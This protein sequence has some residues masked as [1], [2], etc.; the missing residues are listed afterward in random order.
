MSS[1]AHIKLKVHFPTHTGV[2]SLN[3][4]TRG[5]DKEER[6]YFFMAP[7]R[8]FATSSQFTTFHHAVT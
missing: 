4:G 1:I 2:F 5:D 3:F 8:R 6:N 7:S